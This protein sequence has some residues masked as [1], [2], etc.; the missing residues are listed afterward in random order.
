MKWLWVIVGIG[1]ALYVYLW[2]RGRAPRVP[3]APVATRHGMAM[4]EDRELM[5]S[6]FRRE[7]ANYMVR[8]DPDRYLDLYRKAMALE[9]A[10][11][12]A[13]NEEREAQLLII[14]KRYPMYEEFDFIGTRPYVLYSD[15]L[16]RH[17]IEEIEEHYLNL[18]KFQALQRALD[19]DWKFRAAATTEKEFEHLQGYI[20]KIKDTKFRQRLQAAVETFYANGKGNRLTDGDGAVAYEN[21]AF[22]VYY[23][24]HIAE[25]RFGFHFKDTN[26]FGLFGSFYDSDND[27]SYQS[28][29]RSNRRFEAEQHLDHL[30][31]DERI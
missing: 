14:T 13:D 22:T 20:R 17:S 9:T 4:A 27:K 18:V 2:Y 11:G 28:F 6:T 15:A 30:F 1:T 23:V 29:Y 3:T 12:K 10:F 24:P 7:L 16:S 19:P 5:L 8:L 21:A 31:I 26:E 25:N